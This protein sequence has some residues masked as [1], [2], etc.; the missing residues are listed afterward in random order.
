MRPSLLEG[1]VL[2]SLVY[3]PFVLLY[4]ECDTF[5]SPRVRILRRRKTRAFEAAEHWLLLASLVHSLVLYWSIQKGLNLLR[6]YT[7]KHSI[8]QSCY[9]MMLQ[10]LCCRSAMWHRQGEKLAHSWDIPCPELWNPA[11]LQSVDCCR[12]C[13]GEV[14]CVWYCSLS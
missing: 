13:R 9:T 4:W 8:T 14:F 7:S 11:T 3:F 6:S 12:N 1:I 2:W 10:H 5:P